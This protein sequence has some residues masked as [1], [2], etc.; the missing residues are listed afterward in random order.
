MTSTTTTDKSLVNERIQ[1]TLA[2]L[3]GHDNCGRVR[4]LFKTLPTE[5]FAAACAEFIQ[6]RMLEINQKVGKKND[7]LYLA[8]AVQ[9]ALVN[10]N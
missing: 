1:I 6:P 5:K 2:D 9:L 10:E 8:Y 3:V 4:E 7:C